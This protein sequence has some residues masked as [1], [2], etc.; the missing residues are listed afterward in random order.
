MKLNDIKYFCVL[1][2]NGN[3]CMFLKTPVQ[4]ELL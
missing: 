3:I 1:E 4:F 2:K